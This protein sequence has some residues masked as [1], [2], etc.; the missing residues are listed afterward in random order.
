MSKQIVRY[1]SLQGQKLYQRWTPADIATVG[2]YDASDTDTI[3]DVAG[4][5]SQWDDKS[6]NGND[7]AQATGSAQP[8]TG[9]RTQNGLNVLDFISGDT[10]TKAFSADL[11]QPF[12]VYVV[13]KFDRDSGAR[14]TLIANLGANTFYI[15]GGNPNT[16]LWTG[17]GTQPSF[18]NDTGYHLF[19]AT[20]DGNPSEFLV[21]GTSVG[22]INPLGILSPLQGISIGS[23]QNGTGSESLDGTVGEVVIVPSNLSLTDRQ[24]LEGYLAWKWGT[25]ANLD[26]G[27]PYKT[28]KPLR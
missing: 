2:W 20:V 8:I 16:F 3:T 19:E 13:G 18:A 10:L 23:N 1:F 9:T 12:S 17:G 4:A 6:G 26:A 7:V 21:D 5:V 25:V 15:A 22:A 28:L 27:H 11:E 24:K 14:M